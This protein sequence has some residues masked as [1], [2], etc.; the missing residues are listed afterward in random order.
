VKKEQNGRKSLRKLKPIVGCNASQR[1]RRIRSV[2]TYVPEL[3]TVSRSYDKHGKHAVWKGK[4]LRKILG[5][6]KFTRIKD[7]MNL[8]NEADVV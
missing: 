4:I 2:V 7:L 1:R 8:Y 6:E 5:S 3:W